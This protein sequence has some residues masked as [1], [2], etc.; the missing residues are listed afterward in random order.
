MR[1]TGTV[2]AV[3]GWSRVM[4]DIFLV[5]LLQVFGPWIALYLIVKVIQYVYKN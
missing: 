5:G 4:A 2:G 1:L 3:V